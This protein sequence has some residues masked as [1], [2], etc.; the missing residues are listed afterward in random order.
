MTFVSQFNQTAEILMDRLR[1]FAD[2]KTSIHLHNEI[3]NATLDA[4]AQI[5]FGMNT[6]CI[7]DPESKF[8]VYISDI[9]A[10][11]ESGLKD[12]FI[13]VKKSNKNISLT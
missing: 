13:K 9:L 11:I 3:N 10:L 4:V 2:G 1:L 6:N 8:S 12:P 5:G 7:S